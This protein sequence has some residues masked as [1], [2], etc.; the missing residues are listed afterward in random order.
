MRYERES[1]ASP[2]RF[3]PNRPS[4]RAIGSILLGILPIFSL[5][6]RAVELTT[7]I[8]DGFTNPESQHAT[9]VEPD[10]FAFGST[11]VVVSQV[12]RAVRD[13]ASGI[14]FATSTDQG[15]TW[16]AGALPGLTNKDGDGGLA[17]FVT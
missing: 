10:S 5:P 11:I 1:V 7:V 4:R 13:G 15:V 9:A 6:A 14:G 12:G 17:D 2:R 16:T 8:R 3:F